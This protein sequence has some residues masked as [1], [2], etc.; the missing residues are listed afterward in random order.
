MPV[1][2]LPV[3]IDVQIRR[4]IFSCSIGNAYVAEEDDENQAADD[5]GEYQ[6]HDIE[7]L[8]RS[9][10]TSCLDLMELWRSVPPSL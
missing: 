9:I 6:S 4:S 2:L 7:G 5:Y 8:P 10:K 3:Q 1:A